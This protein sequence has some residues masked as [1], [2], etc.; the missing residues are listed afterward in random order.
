MNIG[1]GKPY[2]Y[3]RVRVSD[4][5]L[6]TINNKKAYSLDGL[7]LNPFDEGDVDSYIEEYKNIEVNGVKISDVESIKSFF[8]MK[9]EK[10]IPKK[11][12]V[13]YMSIN[14]GEYKNRVNYSIPL[15]SIDEVV[16][17]K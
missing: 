3:G 8:K 13:R 9:D 12:N 7:N 5:R 1:M 4:I 10:Y 11:E 14:K 17:K 15:D 16:K 6:K 2:G